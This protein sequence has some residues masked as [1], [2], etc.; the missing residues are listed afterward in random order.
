MGL[1]FSWI[2]ANLLGFFLVDVRNSRGKFDEIKE[3]FMINPA[4][5]ASQLSLNAGGTRWTRD[6]PRNSLNF[7]TSRSKVKEQ[8]RTTWVFKGELARRSW[9]IEAIVG[10]EFMRRGS[11]SLGM[12]RGFNSATNQLEFDFN[13]ASMFAPIF[14]T[15][16]ATIAPRSGRDRASIVVLLVRR[17]PSFR[18]ATI[19]RWKS[20]RSRLDRAAI[21][22]RSGRDRGVL[23]RTAYAVGFESVAPAIFTKRGRSRSHGRQIEIRRFRELHEEGQI[24]I[25]W[26]SDRNPTI[27]QSSR[28]EADRASLGR[29]IGEV[30]QVGRPRSRDPPSL[31]SSFVR[32]RSTLRKVPRGNRWAFDHIH[33]TWD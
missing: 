10:A 6:L 11:D 20:P 22:V 15:I 33:L 31:Q 4:P 32:G 8:R 24:A 5:I 19:L 12:G 17:S 25:T 23:P 27:P 21:A 18:P 13:F 26:L 1:Q 16:F 7:F 28:K 30:R 2:E 14:A 9:P 3:K 29:R